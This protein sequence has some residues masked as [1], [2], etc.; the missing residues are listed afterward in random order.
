MGGFFFVVAKS[1][2]PHALPFSFPRFAATYQVK[3]KDREREREE[4][5]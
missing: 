5:E 2:P 1:S 4:K 3:A